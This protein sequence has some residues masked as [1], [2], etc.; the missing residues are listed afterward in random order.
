MLSRLDIHNVRNL[1][2]VHMRD[3]SA[4]SL[5]YGL[6][7][8]GKSSVLEAVHMLGM[9]R[10]FRGAQ[11]R[12]L[13]HH[14]APSC[15]VHGELH[16]QSGRGSGHLALGVSRSRSGEVLIKVGGAASRS[17]AELA[18]CLPV[19]VLDSNSFEL[20]VGPPM[21]RRRFLDWGVFH[22]EHT[23][24]PAWRRFQRA[25][26]QRNA[27][28][29]RGTIDPRE[30]R[31]WTDEFARSGEELK[32]LRAHYFDRML[33]VFN[34]VIQ[35]LLPEVPDL[36]C[37]LRHGWDADAELAEALAQLQESDI[38]R[39]FTQ[40][41]P[42]R[43]DVRFSVGRHPA[44]ETLSRGQ[45]KTMAC[46]LKLCQGRLLV[47]ACHGRRHCVYLI[48]DLPAELD[49]FHLHIV[50]KTLAQMGAQVFI[51]AIDPQPVL[52]AWSS[53]PEDIGMFHVEHGVIS[54]VNRAPNQVNTKHD[55]Q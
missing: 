33:P 6:N 26:R 41:G 49:P 53:R 8:S 17:L 32:R 39:G 13:I 22:V 4:V 52:E 27:L 43:A 46:A 7:G 36:S 31:V 2:D 34:E 45:Q 30:L 37:A 54:A 18:Q 12:S 35:Q 55:T 15:A 20:L 24:L 16:G 42:H 10:S 50:C 25:L 9:G 40:V 51:T 44:A 11:P 47:E 48:D 38:G 19:Q 1:R 21:V 29:R 3:L 14:D 23:F 28:L 5:I